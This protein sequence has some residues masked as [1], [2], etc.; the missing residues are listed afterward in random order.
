MKNYIHLKN[1]ILWTLVISRLANEWANFLFPR[2]NLIQMRSL[3]PMGRTNKRIQLLEHL[4]Q[5]F[6]TLMLDYNA[7]VPN[8]KVVFQWF[9]W[10]L[11]TNSYIKHEYVFIACMMIHCLWICWQWVPKNNT[12]KNL[13]RK[14]PRNYTW[15]TKIFWYVPIGSTIWHHIQAIGLLSIFSRFWLAFELKIFERSF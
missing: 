13:I 1:F 10:N 11:N 2:L 9:I 15:L 12:T 8:N 5:S 14:C 7:M 4:S 6:M 3:F